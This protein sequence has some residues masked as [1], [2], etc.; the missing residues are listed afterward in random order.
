MQI[1]DVRLG[2]NCMHY[3]SY[4]LHDITIVFRK[5]DVYKRHTDKRQTIL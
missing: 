2:T 4:K 3:L 1:G 5:S